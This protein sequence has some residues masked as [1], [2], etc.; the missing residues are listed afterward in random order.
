[1]KQQV[2]PVT[3]DSARQEDECAT[4][5]LT[6]VL[7]EQEYGIDVLCVRE[8]KGWDRVT[9]LPETPAYVRG[10]INLRGSIV[11]VI[12]L[13]LRFSLPAVEYSA[14]TVV[15]VL[16]TRSLDRDRIIGIV[17]DSVSDVCEIAGH[18][19]KESPDLGEMAASHLIEGLA[20]VNDKLIILL[21][22]DQLLD[23]D[24]IGT[25]QLV[26]ETGKDE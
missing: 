22:A 6:F 7:D 17:V 5:F 21:D 13:R 3:A 10:V 15:I 2:L 12:D 9:A 20:T 23:T 19:V 18:E 25:G 16:K 14:T 1:M 11:P 8:I 26:G 24:D 4:Q